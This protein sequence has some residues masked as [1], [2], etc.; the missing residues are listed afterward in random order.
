MSARNTEPIR[1]G[2]SQKLRLTAA[3]REAV[4][5]HRLMV[6]QA[7]SGSGRAEFEAHRAAW[8]RPRGIAIEDGLFLVEFSGGDYTHQEIARQL[9]PC[10]ATPAEVKTG[11]L[12]LVGLGLL[13]AVPDV[14]VPPRGSSSDY[15]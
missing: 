12:R 13:E 9:G 4:D 2:R 8:A 15:Y 5:A 3:G 1:L 7:R 11:V 6:E 14:P 10:G